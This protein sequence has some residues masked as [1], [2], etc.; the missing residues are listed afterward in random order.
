M[1][2]QQSTLQSNSGLVSHFRLMTNK[3]GNKKHNPRHSTLN[4]PVPEPALDS[5]EVAAAAIHLTLHVT[6]LEFFF[7]SD[8][9]ETVSEP[10]LFIFG[11]VLL[12]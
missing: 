7:L 6:P 4:P 8:L 12:Q 1:I 10:E 11:F 5:V 9:N 3:D 2:G